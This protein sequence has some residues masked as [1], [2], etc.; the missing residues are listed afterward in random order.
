MGARGELAW[1]AVRGTRA[2]IADTIEVVFN[3]QDNIDAASKI[4]AYWSRTRS[5]QPE[6]R[7]GNASTSKPKSSSQ[8]RKSDASHGQSSDAEEAEAEDVLGQEDDA[9]LSGAAGGENDE[10]E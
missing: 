10:D 5:V 8:K 9:E 7:D 6:G 2:Q 4:E 3:A 1:L